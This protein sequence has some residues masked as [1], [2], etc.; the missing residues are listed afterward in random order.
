M[1]VPQS[2][3]LHLAVE[4]GE[5]VVVDVADQPPAVE[6]VGAGGAWVVGAADQGVGPV[7]CVL[8]DM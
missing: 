1:A 4:D 2:H 8:L 5:L 3:L 7:G 6:L